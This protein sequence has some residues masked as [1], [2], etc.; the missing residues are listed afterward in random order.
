MHGTL[1]RWCRLARFGERKVVL[2]LRVRGTITRS[3]MPTVRP[4]SYLFL[5]VK[6]H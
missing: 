1:R 3:V 6:S 5:F 4:R 2:T